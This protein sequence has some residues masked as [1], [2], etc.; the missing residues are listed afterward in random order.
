LPLGP[1]SFSVSCDVQIL[2]A[3]GVNILEFSGS[4][5]QILQLLN[6]D[7]EGNGTVQFT[8]PS[9]GVVTLDGV[10]W[11]GTP[12]TWRFGSCTFTET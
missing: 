3:N 2:P 12:S 1:L 5:Y 9:G 11:P 10:C 8:I 7:T 6:A 4:N